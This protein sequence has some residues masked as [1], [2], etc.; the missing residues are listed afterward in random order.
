MIT[1]TS[2]L[3]KFLQQ[4]NLL[5]RVYGVHLKDSPAKH[6]SMDDVIKALEGISVLQHLEGRHSGVH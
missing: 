4:I 2:A 3:C 6:H 5:N 1:Q